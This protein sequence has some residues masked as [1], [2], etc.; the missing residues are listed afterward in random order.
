VLSGDPADERAERGSIKIKKR[1]KPVKHLVFFLLFATNQALGDFNSELRE[2]GLKLKIPNGFETTKIV[3]NE[4]MEYGHAVT[5]SAKSIEIRFA[6]RR[7]SKSELDRFQ[8]NKPGEGGLD[9]ND[10]AAMVAAVHLNIGLGGGQLK[11]P[12]YFP[13]DAVKREFGADSGMSFFVE[14]ANSEFGKGFKNI[15]AFALHRKNLGQVYVFIL[16]KDKKEYDKLSK[17]L[18]YS[19]KLE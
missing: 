1:G 7:M 13:E 4:D 15:M 14:N 11:G 16:Y 9:P 8:N 6:L 5:N 19:I 3:E 18:F 10:Y 17:Q 2:W 12:S